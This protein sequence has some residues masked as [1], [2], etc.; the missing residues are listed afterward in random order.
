MQIVLKCSNVYMTKRK[1]FIKLVHMKTV[2]YNVN[3]WVYIDP[4]SRIHGCECL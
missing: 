1:M 4:V 3:I 2:N